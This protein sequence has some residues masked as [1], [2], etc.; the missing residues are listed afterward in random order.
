MARSAV[1]GICGLLV[2]LGAST[3]LASEPASVEQPEAPA[4]TSRD[5][6]VTRLVDDLKVLARAP[7][8]WDAS[9]WRRFAVLAGVTVGLTVVDEE[10]QQWSQ[11]DRL[12]L[13]EPGYDGGGRE[14]LIDFGRWMGNPETLA[15][16]TAVLYLSGAI[17]EN[18]RL[19]ETGALAAET[20]VM[21]TLLVELVKRTVDRQRPSGQGVYTSW[22]PS[23]QGSSR[24]SFPS[25]HAAAMFSLATVLARQ[26]PEPRWVAPV[27]YGLAT[28]TAAAR[29][30]ENRHWTSDVVAGACL[31]VLISDVVIR[32][33]REHTVRI[34][35]QVVP[36]G[37]GVTVSWQF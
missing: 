25:G 26:Y 24:H 31:G 6:A 5:S 22:G 10:I 2:W 21:T 9:E 8:L 20:L 32:R 4:G 18:E 27:A 3:V 13:W 34:A 28:L 15:G 16:V 11:K 36:G 14:E 23:Y 33:H 37:G 17:G 7:L 12:D 30:A 1:Q 35:P 29:V 19:R